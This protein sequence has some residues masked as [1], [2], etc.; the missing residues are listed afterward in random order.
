VE[1]A[2][3]GAIGTTIDLAGAAGDAAVAAAIQAGTMMT[4]LVEAQIRADAT[5]S[6]LKA[7]LNDP[8]LTADGRAQLEGLIGQLETAKAAGDIT[9]ILSLTGAPEVAGEL[10]QTTE[11]RDTTV[12]VES[13]NGPAVIS[14][15]DSI[16]TADRLAIVRVESR[17]GPA[18]QDY[19]QGLAIRDR[20]ALIRVESRN[21]PAV[22]T[23]LD[24]LTRERLAIIR[25]ETRGGPAVDQYLDNLASQVRNATIGQTRGAPTGMRGAPT[26][27]AGMIGAPRV[28]L[29]TVTLDLE[30]TG[31]A[32]KGALTRADRGRA[33][34]A[35]I[36]AYERENGTGWRQR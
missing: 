27:A 21:G 9:A 7:S 1:E 36:R 15:L 16:A 23:Y 20:L 10:D 33:M 12:T 35:D 4:P 28:A 5:I 32:D 26:L 24:G 34:V 17:N 25:V 31:R 14:Y 29:G 13:R 11:D 6:S 2:V 3:L 8:N 19:L 22:D 30:L 18:V